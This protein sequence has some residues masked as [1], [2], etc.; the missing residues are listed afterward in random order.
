M[1]EPAVDLLRRIIRYA[2]G[3][4][5]ASMFSESPVLREQLEAHQAE[6]DYFTKAHVLGLTEDDARMVLDREKG[7]ATEYRFTRKQMISRAW[8]QAIG[9]SMGEPYRPFQDDAEQLWATVRLVGIRVAE[10]P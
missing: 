7:L 2:P 10:R 8:T 9:H 6:Q 1:T 4:G 5:L 3:A